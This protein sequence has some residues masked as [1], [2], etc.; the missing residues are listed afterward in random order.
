MYVKFGGIPL[1][2]LP[3]LP[4][5]QKRCSFTASFLVAGWLMADDSNLQSSEPLP[6]ISNHWTMCFYSLSI[7]YNA[8][9]EIKVFG[10]QDFL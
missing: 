9:S 10:L 2:L 4:L 8:E 5:T 6:S 1:L 7:S 3:Y